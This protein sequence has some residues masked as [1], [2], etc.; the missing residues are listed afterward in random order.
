MASL[1]EP[2]TT[3]LGRRRR[4]QQLEGGG[5]GTVDVPRDETMARELF[6]QP[7][8]A[9][10]RTRRSADVE[11]LLE[12][13]GE[14]VRRGQRLE[15]GGRVPPVVRADDPAGD[16]TGRDGARPHPLGRDLPA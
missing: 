1:Y 5:D 11:R 2:V 10:E 7:A 8:Q 13:E 12:Q 4:R 16:R 3:P 14:G 9:I 6:D 15:M